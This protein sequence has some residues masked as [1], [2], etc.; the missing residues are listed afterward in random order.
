MLSEENVNIT[1]CC[2][3]NVRSSIVESQTQLGRICKTNL[4]AAL[5]SVAH[6]LARFVEGWKKRGGMMMMAVDLN[7]NC[8]IE[9]AGIARENLL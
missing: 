5:F 7:F 3:V 2:A 1:I 9:S 6:C 8:R 4:I